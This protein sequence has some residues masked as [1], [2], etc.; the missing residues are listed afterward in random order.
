MKPIMKEVTIFTAAQTNAL[1]VKELIFLITNTN[2]HYVKMKV[3]DINAPHTVKALT[4]IKFI[5]QDIDLYIF[6]LQAGH[7]SNGLIESIL[8]EFLQYMWIWIILW[9]HKP[10]AYNRPHFILC[11]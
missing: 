4:G 5:T 6:K 3:M 2:V 1:V 11:R 10:I 8:K 9:Q 7:F